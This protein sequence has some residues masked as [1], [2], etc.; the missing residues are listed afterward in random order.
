[1]D[2]T[3]PAHHLAVWAGEA[4]EAGGM[5]IERS[6]GSVEEAIEA[7]LSELGLSEQEAF[8]EIVQ[9]PRS[10]F[11]GLRAVPAIV[12]VRP[13]QGRV[14]QAPEDQAEGVT[15]FL[16]GLLDAM[17]LDADV[18]INALEGTTYVDVWGVQDDQDMGLLI[19]K[20]G[21]TLEALQELVRGHVQRAGAGPC[22]V[23]VDVEDYRKRRNKQIEARA[24][25]A[26]RQV[27][28]SGKPISLEPMNAYE[29]KIVHDAV[30]QL[31]GLET[32]SE[33]E[34]PNRRVVI[35]R[36]RRG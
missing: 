34:Q 12:R 33:G 1:M 29:R 14:E 5:E 36:L 24:Q 27:K 26:G 21:H 3:G 7:A 6:G 9:E 13:A 10:G 31:D 25:D 32:A 2:P 28:R 22:R 4:V 18:E 20:H 8:I 30:P 16:E 23:L 19:G 11:L 35:R 15:V 17:G